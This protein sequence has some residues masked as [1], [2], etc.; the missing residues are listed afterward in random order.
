MN[1]KLWSLINRRKERKSMSIQAAEKLLRQVF[2][3]TQFRPSQRWVIEQ[4]LARRDAFAV[5]PTAGGKSICYQIPAMLF[6]GVTVVLS[7]LI[8]LMKDQ[9]DAL[10]QLGVAA[11]YLNSSLS[12]VQVEQ[13]LAGVRGGKF[14]LLYIAPERLESEAFLAVLSKLQISLVAVDEAHCISTW[15]H[16]FRPS[17]R[18]IPRLIKQLPDKPVVLALT[19]T[20]TAEVQRDIAELLE[21]SSE[22]MHI[23]SFARDNLLFSV[24]RVADKRDFIERFLKARRGQAGIIYTSSRRAVDQLAQYLHERGYA[25]ARYH[26]GMDD[27]ARQTAQERFS[28]DRVQVMVATNAFGMGIDKSNV[29]LVLHFQLPRDLESYYQEAGRAGR[30]GLASECVLLYQPSDVHIHRHLIDRAGLDDQRKQHELHKLW[31]M[32]QYCRMNDCLTTVILRY[33]GEEASADCGKCFN[34][35]QREHGEKRDFTLE[36][37]K[38]FSCIKRM[39]ERFGITMVARVLVGS[40]SKQVQQFGLDRLST[41][42]IMREYTQKQVASL[43]QLLLGEG[44]LDLGSTTSNL[45]VAQLAGRAYAVLQGQERVYLYEEP[46]VTWREEEPAESNQL[47]EKLRQ[48]RKTLS[49]QE[50]VPPYA[51][52][53]D[54]VLKQMCRLLPHDETQMLQMKGIGERKFAKYGA[55]FLAVISEYTQQN[56]KEPQTPAVASSQLEQLRQKHAQ[57]Y[58][59]WTQQEEEILV[60]GFRA[61]K[62]LSQLAKQLGRQQGGV[63]ARLQKLGLIKVEED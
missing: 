16:D 25:V 49:E 60:A 22:Q 5:M 52:F 26:A 15:G 61:G 56:G 4:V 29:C 28:Y 1:G 45:P 36:A 48:L 2:G 18:L 54:S 41:Y 9:V 37:Q 42:G 19:A 44:Y 7:P 31:Q 12:A 55:Q 17:Y 8:S 59:R 58:Q 14:K 32:E 53:H 21:I 6:P 34:C 47:F 57:A 27:V 35:Y 39:K 24:R 33:F 3:Y 13:R 20:A 46:Q 30:D 23:A 62:S 11:T 51:I 40:R 38:I 63:L 43:C 50:K 10:Q